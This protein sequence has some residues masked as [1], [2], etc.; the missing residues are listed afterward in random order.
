MASRRSSRRLGPHRG[1]GA[2][3]AR[4]GHCRR[5]DDRDR[6]LTSSALRLDLH[7]TLVVVGAFDPDHAGGEGGSAPGKNR[8]CARGLG[9]FLHSGQPHGS[10]GPWSSSWS[11]RRSSRGRS[12]STLWRDECCWSRRNCGRLVLWRKFVHICGV[13]NTCSSAESRREFAVGADD[14]VSSKSSVSDYTDG[15]LAA[16]GK[17]EAGIPSH[18]GGPTA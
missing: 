1:P 4:R 12:L 8:T 13:R 17:A 5:A 14:C 2:P 15:T 16:T 3:C 18:G 6:A 11:S 9:T 10:N 7:A